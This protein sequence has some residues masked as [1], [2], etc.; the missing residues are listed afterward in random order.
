MALFT[1]EEAG[2]RVEPADGAPADLARTPR[3]PPACGAS[4]ALGR[5]R[6]ERRRDVTF[7]GQGFI[8]ERLARRPRLRP[9]A[10]DTFFQTNSVAGRARSGRK[11]A[12]RTLAR[13]GGRPLPRP[14][15]P[16]PVDDARR[17]QP[18]RWSTA[19]S[20]SKARWRT[21]A[22]RSRTASRARPSSPATW[23]RSSP[24]R[25]WTRAASRHPS[26]RSSPP[27]GRPAPEGP[28][29]PRRA[30]SARAR[31][32]LVQPARSAV[33]DLL[34]LVKRSFCGAPSADRSVPHTPHLECV[35]LLHDEQPQAPAAQFARTCGLAS[36]DFESD[37]AG[38]RRSMSSASRHHGGL[39]RRRRAPVEVVPFQGA[40]SHRA[41][42]LRHQ[43]QQRRSDKTRRVS[44]QRVSARYRRPPAVRRSGSDAGVCAAHRTRGSR[45][46]WSGLQSFAQ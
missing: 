36:K 32:R 11:C 31:L 42:V 18:T 40:C 9:A 29:R 20:S 23:R 28:A 5:R 30:A 19:S 1:T 44:Q 39:P 41:D 6:R 45:L 12:R 4:A 24:R 3:S 14:A 25:C 35:A 27:T 2:A 33:R 8:T 26:A 22:T 21:R 34:E 38:D 46:R 37:G 10:T 16:A 17:G 43:W 15:P 7:A 13:R